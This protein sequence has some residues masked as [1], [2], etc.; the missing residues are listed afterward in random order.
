M[1]AV[2]KNFTT[3]CTTEDQEIN[4]VVAHKDG[5]L[6]LKSCESE[7][8]SFIGSIQAPYLA[9]LFN[10]QTLELSAWTSGFK[11]KLGQENKNGESWAMKGIFANSETLQTNDIIETTRYTPTLLKNSNQVL[12]RTVTLEE[13]YAIIIDPAPTEPLFH[14]AIPAII[15]LN[16]LLEK[17]SNDSKENINEV[18]SK[19]VNCFKQVSGYDR[20][21]MYKFDQ[22]WNGKI[23]AEAA[24][25]L[26]QNFLGL[27]FPSSD[28]PKPA[29]DLFVK[30]RVRCIV[31]TL[32]SPSI[33][34]GNDGKNGTLF[35][36]GDIS[37]RA[38][39]PIHLEYLKNMDVRATL[40]ISILVDGQLW[41]LLTCHHYDGGKK[42]NP[43][44]LDLCRIICDLWGNFVRK[45]QDVENALA[46]QS[47][48]NLERELRHCVINAKLS[49]TF[50]DL[51]QS[52][53]KKILNIIDADG[54]LI[55][56]EGNQVFLHGKQPEHIDNVI[57]LL[58]DRALNTG[59]S[60]FSTNDIK[61]HYPEIDAISI[62]E[63]AG[64]LFYESKD[65]NNYILAWRKAEKHQETWAGDPNKLITANG[66]LSPRASFEE[67]SKTE[68]NK[69][70]QWENSSK[71]SIK[72]ILISL[73]ECRWILER[74][75]AEDR[76]HQARIRAE[77][78][79]SELEHAALHDALTNLP[80]RR[81]L[82]K[83][84]RDAQK[85]IL[86][87]EDH[88]TAL[89]IDLDGFKLINDTLGHDAGDTL[90]RHI[91]GLI[92]LKKYPGDFVARVGGDEFVLIARQS[93]EKNEL[94]D[95]CQAIINAILDPYYIN[96]ERVYCSA[97]IGVAS[98]T[99]HEEFET[100]LTRADMAL[101]EAKRS[102][103][104]KFCFISDTLEE[105]YHS[106][107]RLNDDVRRG[108]DADEFEIYFQLQYDSSGRNL[109]GAEALL[110]WN[111]PYNGVLSPDIFLTAAEETGVLDKLFDYTMKSSLDAISIFERNGIILPRI[112]INVSAGLISRINLERHF[113]KY[114]DSGRF[115]SL[116]IVETSDLDNLSDNVRHK[117]DQL[118]EAG[119]RIEVDDFGTGHTS[120]IGLLNVSPD[121]I[122]I[123]KKLT[124]PITE[125]HTAHRILQS[126][127]D[128]A[129]NLE[130]ETIAEGVETKDQHEILWRIGCDKL[131][132]YF[133]SKP[134]PLLV[135]LE[136]AKS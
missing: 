76:A 73:N 97:S 103:K 36:I 104:S 74:R 45:Q 46:H 40:N 89:H 24:E 87:N 134:S 29:R 4:S 77:S 99:S 65:H 42:L 17:N 83:L 113:D 67:W 108:F 9:A 79:T 54:C 20:V 38:V 81:Y 72:S 115:I 34:I 43:K 105:K 129:K 55:S 1:N 100:L 102:G 106:W 23:I 11:E 63:L 96:G 33:I 119:Y 111:H 44:D 41:G 92:N 18:A 14:D 56:F 107:K 7:P 126:I 13:Y 131:Q 86:S 2:E 16:N 95:R 6:D 120:V 82:N 85:N 136:K 69:S 117:I 125:N 122:K 35:D 130:I 27:T 121:A 68:I 10:K 50:S 127:V 39:S 51:I 91:S 112:G 90:L 21:M 25:D 3:A 28:I 133:F 61:N 66:R 75:Q 118:R 57:H 84:I 22:D 31:D 64:V 101:Y 109:S 88:I 128:I 110:R 59:S 5:A 98:A 32:T 8:I 30:N 94:E 135:S 52:Y 48:S 58:K 116:E 80:N 123:D 124:Q 12:Y 19:V 53:S 47:L 49:E 15:E 60:F 71:S 78:V 70:R 37:E 93:I 132:G 62:S 114:P 26:K